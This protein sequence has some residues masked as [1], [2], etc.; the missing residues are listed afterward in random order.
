MSFEQARVYSTSVGLPSR[1]PATGE[2]PSRYAEVENKLRRFIL[3]FFVN[4][5][6]K[7]RDQL[8]EHCILGNYCLEVDVAHLILFDE[9]LGHR[10][11]EEPAEILPLFEQAALSVA[12]RIVYAMS[13]TDANATGNANGAEESSLAA[14]STSEQTANDDAMTDDTNQQ[15]LDI[16]TEI[17]VVLISNA[18]VTS[19]RDLDATHISKLVRVPGIIISASPLVSKA[20]LLFLMCRSCRHLLR[21]QVNSGFG[22]VQAPTKCQA[23]SVAGGAVNECPPN[24]YVVVH[25]RS[26]FVDQQ[27]L[28][29]QESPENVPVGEMP[30]NIILTA[31]RTLT[32]RAIPGSRCTVLGVYSIYQSKVKAPGAV[33][34]RN[35]YVRAV[36]MELS[37]GQQSRD[38]AVFT[39]EEEEEFLALSRTPDLFSTFAQSIA[40][41][42]W[43]HED[44]K[45]AIACLLVGGS[46][47]LLPDN[48]RLRGDIN[49]LLLGDPGTAKS[50]LLKFVEKVAPIAIYTSGKGSSAAGLTASVQRDPATRDFYL[51]GGAMVLADGGVVC[52]EEFDKMREEDR[53]AIHEAMEQ[54][55]I[56]IA[57]AGITTV[58]NSRTSVLAAANPLFGRYDD[59]KSPGENIDFQTTILSRFDMIFI[60]KDEHSR[61]HDSSVAEHVLN[62]Q[63]HG[64]V[65]G[66]SQ[67][68]PNPV[69]EGAI[70]MEKMQRYVEYC[71]ARCAPRLSTQA[72]ELLVSHFVSIREENHKQE[73]HTNVRSSVPVTVRQLEAMIR[74]AEAIAK[75]HLQ[76]VATE[77]HVREAIRLFD[78]STVNAI[79]Q[80][81]Y[82]REMSAEVGQ[83]EEK[84]KQRLPVGWHTSYATLL[85]EFVNGRYNFSKF[86]L[87][88]ALN[89]ME[90]RDSIQF[91]QQRQA[92]FR[93]AP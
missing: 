13:S 60:I 78:A 23:P 34:V 57:K 58:L 25:D 12:K 6:Y 8:R 80:D 45:R 31:D 28:K 42:I 54:Q 67:A 53:V 48:I 81:M 52:I 65:A 84:L 70:P 35:P 33:A 47:R 3:D 69:E 64:T 61:E 2:E 9:D 11:S 15:N 24:P 77:D 18:N 49:V 32:N 68:K 85:R 17:Q 40:P 63:L 51:E 59:L 56:S 72:A 92:I 44:I 14:T 19:I 36:G 30:R 76:P 7:Y 79:G 46:K 71:R 86:A 4:N 22:G 26:I 1:D 75:I 38:N 62:T 10:L 89:V 90:R 73:L 83:V 82:S 55:T 43:G 93:S 88:T 87:D 50:Q 66:R 37:S 74:I 41:S 27:V 39:E 16:P 21:L 5:S 20:T 91:R 29:L